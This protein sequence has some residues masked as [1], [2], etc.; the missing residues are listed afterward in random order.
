MS[1]ADLKEL[2]KERRRDYIVDA[3]EKLFFAKGY[4]GVSMS[5]I[6][7]ALKINKAT[8]YIYFKNK[9]SLY[10]AV[11]RRGLLIM[12]DE[13]LAPQ[14]KSRKGKGRLLR[15]CE[16]FFRYCREHPEH[17]RELCYARTH[18]FD[19]SQVDS[20][21]EQA[22][23]AREI[24]GGLNSA[25]V[26]GLEDGTITGGVDPLETAIF[27]MST[28]ENIASPGPVME[29]ALSEGMKTHDEYM[30]HSMALL[31]RAI[32]ARPKEMK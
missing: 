31:A 12:R 24:I 29:W 6:A 21:M 28:C 13:L 2:E 1:I 32:A 26:Q 10:F 30:A 23:I 11:L 16:A 8:L 7:D 27:V 15:M 14:K 22:T 20:A 3:A 9:D 4:D 19:M 18:R 5:D 17:Y 25:I